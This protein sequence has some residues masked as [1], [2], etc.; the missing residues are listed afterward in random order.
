MNIYNEA[1]D[2]I[3]RAAKQYEVF[4]QAAAVLE[5]AGSFEQAAKEAEQAA[6]AA[7][8]ACAAAKAELAKARDAVAA[9]KAKAKQV[10]AEAHAKAADIQAQAEAAAQAYVRKEREIAQDAAA[11]TLSAANARR[12]ALALECDRLAAHKA[13]LLSELGVI[14]GDIAAK[15]RQVKE[16]N[17]ALE[18]LRARL[19]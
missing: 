2:A 18:S 9:E 17:Q 16:L 4:V 6:A 10:E 11:A 12:D 14:D 15:A 1:A 5:R 19:G 3:K 7:H 8:E 13:A